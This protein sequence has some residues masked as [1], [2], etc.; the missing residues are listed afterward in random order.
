VWTGIGAAGTA[1]LGILAYGEGA[2]LVRVALLVG[3]VAC[4]VGLKFVAEH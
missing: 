4:I 1:V 2:T 3:L